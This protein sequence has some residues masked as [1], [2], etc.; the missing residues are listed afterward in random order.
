MENVRH[1][2]LFAGW[3]LMLVVLS[4]L[5]WSLS[6]TFSAMV[7]IWLGSSNFNHCVL[8]PVASLLL[9]WRRR[10]RL[11]RIPLR[12]SATGVLLFAGCVALW[13]VGALGHV[14]TLQ[15]LA[16]VAMITA[17]VWAVLG[18]AVARDLAFP[19]AYLV[20]MVP[21]GE[22]LMPYLMGLTADMTVFAARLSGVSVYKDGLFFTIPNG[23]FRIVE[24]CSGIRMLIAS[25]A[26]GVLFAHLAFWSWTKRCI[27]VTAMIVVSLVANTVRAYIVV[28]IGYYTGMETIA[29]HVTL[30]YVVFGIVI[31]AMLL[32]GSRFAEVDHYSF[33]KE[34]DAPV[35]RM[36]PIAPSLAAAATIMAMMFAA[37]AAVVAVEERA[38]GRP[39]APPMLLP[40]ASGSWSGPAAMRGDWAP[41]FIGHDT[42]QSGAYRQQG[43]GVVDAFMLSYARQ[44]Q[45]EELI[46]ALNRIFDPLLWTLVR[47]S[48]GETPIAGLGALRYRE[49]ELRSERGGRR[50]V[51]YWYIVDGRPRHRA[52]E[53]KLRELKNSVLGRPTPGT[54]V[55]I[56]ARFGD[57]RD[58]AARALDAFTRELYARDYPPNSPIR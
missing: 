24:A 30:G 50:L 40:V 9:M 56:G 47:E 16:V 49:I 44:R 10:H 48:D 18:Y 41:A 21:F 29:S 15:N 46:N 42:M 25:V 6:G 37:P 32:I 22:F 8:V 57:D 20:F 35:A 34:P 5:L 23:S 17:A 36:G 54:F 27:F 7:N 1:S 4:G 38:A 31:V 2:N 19:L 3:A 53:I 33:E 52:I 26:V 43:D 11:A 51:R 14:S 12:A 28:M 58:A 13:G 39:E 55:A 45:G